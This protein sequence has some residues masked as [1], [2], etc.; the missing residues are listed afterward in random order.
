MIKSNIVIFLVFLLH[1][2][3]SAQNVHRGKIDA[4]SFSLGTVYITN[5]TNGEKTF[6]DAS[7]FFSITMS[8]NHVLAFSGEKINKRLVTIKKENLSQNIFLVSI[9]PKT[10]QLQEVEINKNQQLNASSLGIV[11]K[12]VKSYTPAERKLRTAGEFKWYS[13]FLML[14]RAKKMSVDGLINKIS[15]RT[16]M[17]KKELIIERQEQNQKKLLNL[18]SEN[19]FLETLKIPAENLTGFLMIAVEDNIILDEIAQKNIIGIRFRLIELALIFR[20]TSITE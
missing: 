1:Y 13:P 12:D 5:T 3:I 11:S 14:H 8:E 19:F 6:A 2:N 18:F 20:N 17:L 15:G 9:F 16:A 4:G 7:G 10:N